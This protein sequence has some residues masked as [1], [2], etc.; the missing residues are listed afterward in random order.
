VYAVELRFTIA[1]LSRAPS[2][3]AVIEGLLRAPDDLYGHVE[4]VRIR[5]RHDCF[6]AVLFVTADSAHEAEVVCGVIGVAAATALP[7][8]RFAGVRPWPGAAVL[9]SRPDE[10]AQP[11]GRGTVTDRGTP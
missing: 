1:D 7:T 2:A 8:V 5:R 3:D 6:H 9:R 10:A 4:H 11:P